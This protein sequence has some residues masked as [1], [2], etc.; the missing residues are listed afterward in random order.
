M[1]LTVAGTNWSGN[2]AYRAAALHHPTTVEQVQGLVAAARRV[3]ALGSRHSFTDIA[4]SG[5]LLSLAELEAEI[6]VDHDAGTVSLPGG[7]TYAQLAG[8][9]DREGVAL[10]NLASLPHISVAG[11]VATATHGSGDANGNLATA[12]VGLELVTSSG[13]L[14]HARKGDEQFDGL[15]VGLGALGVVTGLTLTVEPFYEMRQRV[16]E[17]L[18]W[19]ALFEHF[20][21]ITGSGESV[22]LFHRFGE[23]IQ[24]AWVKTRVTAD[25]AEQDRDD[26]F[27]A[28]P[29]SS[30]HN[31]VPGSD[32]A[33][34]TQQLGVPGPW[35][36]RLP[37]FRSGFVPSS[38]EEIQSEFFV[39]REHAVPAI[40]A[41]RGLSAT[42]QPLLLISE[43]RTI[44]SDSLWLSPQHGRRT[45]ALHFTW[46]RRQDEVERVLGQ[47][48][49]ALAPF[50]ARP[51]WG[52][53][54]TAR[55]AQIRPHYERM[56]DFLRLREQ[57]DPRGAFGNDWLASRVLEG[58]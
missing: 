3:R 55:A 41:A 11:A 21:E 47:L 51:H 6:T 13:E 48:E 9:L 23:G 32:P 8:V 44:A 56:E 7:V 33:N 10:H 26:L 15:V 49:I 36:E 30:P 4:D 57:L 58:A 14:V 43:L 19:E 35:S 29:A 34:C 31:P 38:G 1:D 12:V 50:S 54:F 22:S 28:R 17:G 39:A 25:G 45:V 42:I 20:D 40:E 16:F 52:K 27:G 37:H 24:Q 2:Y 18:G 5:E 53:L 46:R